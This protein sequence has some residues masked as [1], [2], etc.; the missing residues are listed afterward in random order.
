MYSL[1]YG[2]TVSM[3]IGK[4][5][6]EPLAVSSTEQEQKLLAA[7]IISHLQKYSSVL[8]CAKSIFSELASYKQGRKLL[9]NGSIVSSVTYFCLKLAPFNDLM[10]PSKSIEEMKFASSPGVVYSLRVVHNSP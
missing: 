8:F 2:V 4:G 6:E 3:K 9:R 5:W 10:L 1:F 7:I